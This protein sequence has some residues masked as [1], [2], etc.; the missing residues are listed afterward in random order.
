MRTLLAALPLLT[1]VLACVCVLRPGWRRMH[2]PVLGLAVLN[3]VLTPL[4]SGEWFYQRAEI[5]DYDQA[6]ARGDFTS[7]Q[8][9]L[10]RH[11]PRLLPRMIGIAAALLASLAVWAVL[12]LRGARGRPVSAPASAVS[13]G[14]VVLSVLAMLSQVYL[15]MTRL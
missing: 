2:V 6:I 5:P 8:D 12:R 14:A 13:A 15:V 1:A 9:L 4:T 11:D 3:L 7:Y 10:G